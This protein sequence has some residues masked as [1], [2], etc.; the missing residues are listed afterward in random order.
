[1]QIE[2]AYADAESEILVALVVR[3][4]CRVDEAVA[5]SNVLARLAAPGET[6]G[7]AIFGRRADASAPLAP[8]DRI[9][10][11]RPLVCDAK[12][13]RSARGARMSP[14]SPQG[15]LAPKRSARRPIR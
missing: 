4:G 12:S 15:R 7:Y 8:G 6:L 14:R 1:M 2:I 5:Q 11:T 10:I 9:E 13:A 3:D